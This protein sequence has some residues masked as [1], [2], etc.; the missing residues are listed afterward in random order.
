MT[1]RPEGASNTTVFPS[2]WRLGST[3]PGI[4]QMPCVTGCGVGGG[5]AGVSAWATETRPSARSAMRARVDI[6][7]SLHPP[8]IDD[9]VLVGTGARLVR[10]Q[11]N[12]ELG[13]LHRKQA[14]LEALPVHQHRFALGRQPLVELAWRDDPTGS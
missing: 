5:T 2:G 1:I 7:R 14:P 4:S 9:I 10:G 8:A 12:D 6:H 3:P 13:D 11:E